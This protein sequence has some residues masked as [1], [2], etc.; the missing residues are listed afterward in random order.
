MKIQV[1]NSYETLNSCLLCYPVNYRITDKSN[2][3]YNKVN[4]SLAYNQYNNYVNYLIEEGVKV[5]FLDVTDSTKQVYAKDVG[6]VIDNI[7]FISKMTLKERQKEIEAIKKVALEKGLSYYIMQN[8]IEGGDVAVSDKVVFVGLSKR[9]NIKAVIELQQIL[10]LKKI[11]KTVIPI[12]FDNNML[13][14]DC[15]FS[16]LD[17][18]SAIISP[19]VYDRGIIEDYVENIIDITKE[20]AD[21]FGTNIVYL[22]GKRVVTSSIS[23]GDKLKGLGYKVKVLDF[24]EIVKGD[25]SIACVT[26]TLLRE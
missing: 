26:L 18:D 6:F 16:L 8:N 1:N 21:G 22:G 11:K 20:E 15:V 13:H 10:D 9:T 19:Y 17:K 4:Y 14:L 24:S 12:N 7:L 3:F 23:V 5:R 2:R 25:G